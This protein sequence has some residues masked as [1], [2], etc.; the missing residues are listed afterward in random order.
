MEWSCRRFFPKIRYD[1][2]WFVTKIRGFKGRVE[3]G[4]TSRPR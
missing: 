2:S 1:D 3:R 4:K